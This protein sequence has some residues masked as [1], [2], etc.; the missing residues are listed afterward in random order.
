MTMTY[1]EQQ[2]ATTG[3][4]PPVDT[5]HP[6]W[7]VVPADDRFVWVMD[8]DRGVLLLDSRDGT[9]ELR[10]ADPWSSCPPT[11]VPKHYHI[12][13]YLGV[14]A[15]IVWWLR[16]QKR[17]AKHDTNV[18]TWSVEGDAVVFTM[19]EQW[20][21]GT[22]GMHQ[23]RLHY[24][25]AWGRYVVEMS[26]TLKARRALA[27]QEFCNVIP[28]AIG[29]TR[30]G[31]GK[32]QQMVWVDADGIL[33]GMAKNPL[34]SN[35]VG[36]QDI[37]GS[38]RIG[39]GGFLG[40]VTEHDMNP[41]VEILQSDP[42]VGACTCDNL[43]DEHLLVLPAGGMHNPDGWFHLQAQYRLFSLP[44][45][46]AEEIARQAQP[47]E[48][49]PMLAWKFQYAPTEGPIPA[50]LNRVTLPGF[51]PYQK[52]DMSIPVTWDEP[53]FPCALWT[54]SLLPEADLYWD[55]EIGHAGHRSLR[56]TVTG[57]EKRFF[58]GSGPTIHTDE[59][60]RYRVSGYV[61]TQGDIRAWIEGNEILFHTWNSVEAHP[62]PVVGP[63]SDWTYVETT[64]V[65]RG[66]DAPFFA[67]F[68]VADGDGMA[69]FDE[70]AFEP[71][72]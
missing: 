27:A 4:T 49:G 71:I 20:T 43:M 65:A 63:N 59:G 42:P 44:H 17:T 52:N 69:W 23:G 32:Y 29:D 39:E 28:A 8:G 68:L 50:D 26:T 19:Q 48:Y 2:R 21:D 13:T 54:A 51:I 11:Q 33:R 61:R 10:V 25:P 41:V 30:L 7:R 62:T 40:W 67:F 9:L 35:S 34:W 31:R 66:E 45:A 57:G 46:M 12:C 14:R 1:L 58:P 70:L 5:Y 56:I 64:Y 37:A 72:G 6:D 22:T 47:V 36:A 16:D 53:C 38:R 18:L 24:K 55:P 60:Q 15:T 3:W